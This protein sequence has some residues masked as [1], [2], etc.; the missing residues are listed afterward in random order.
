MLGRDGDEDVDLVPGQLGKVEAAV[1][2]EVAHAGIGQP[3][4]GLEGCRA[5]RSRV[6]GSAS[7]ISRAASAAGCAPAA[8][9]FSMR[10]SASDSRRWISETVRRSRRRHTLIAPTM[11]SHGTV[12]EVGGRLV[13][14]PT[15]GQQRQGCLLHVEDILG[16]QRRERVPGIFSATRS[17]GS[18]QTTRRPMRSRAR[19]SGAVD[20]ALGVQHHGRPGPGARLGIG[21][22]GDEQ[23]GGLA[24]P[25]RR[26]GDERTLRGDAHRAAAFGI[27]AEFETA[28]HG[29]AFASC[30][31][32][33]RP[34]VPL[35]SRLGVG[36]FGAK[37]S[38]TVKANGE[39]ASREDRGTSPRWRKPS[40]AG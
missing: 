28:G 23:T 37:R 9:R 21:Q 13:A 5:N 29:C 16:L 25:G 33:R 8:F 11:R 27:N 38:R 12:A 3:L 39:K 6:R 20:L 18:R 1:T 32:A 31:E 7:I 24:G 40:T 15:L 34:N 30:C 17:S 10:S 35:T 2:D 26:D 19:L 4:K 14:G 36:G 22:I